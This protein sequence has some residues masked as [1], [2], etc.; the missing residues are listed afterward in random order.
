MAGNVLKF[1]EGPMAETLSRQFNGLV[2]RLME[3]GMTT[4]QVWEQV[5]QCIK[6]AGMV[7]VNGV[8]TIKDVRRGT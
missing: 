3:L 5:M 1:P 4:E 6:D 2:A 7:E 8:W